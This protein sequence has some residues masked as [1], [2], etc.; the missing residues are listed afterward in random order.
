MVFTNANTKEQQQMRTAL[1]TK[2]T[3]TMSIDID[4]MNRPAFVPQ[5]LEYLRFRYE[6]EI[7]ELYTE[8]IEHEFLEVGDERRDTPPF[9]KYPGAQRAPFT[10]V[11]EYLA[12]LRWEQDEIDYA[13]VQDLENTA[14]K[15]RVMANPIARPLVLGI[16]WA[17]KQVVATRVVRDVALVRDLLISEMQEIAATAIHF[18][19]HAFVNAKTENEE[20]RAEV[21]VRHRI[22]TIYGRWLYKTRASAKLMATITVSNT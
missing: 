19:I 5:S 18:I 20:K 1:L 2:M 9:N 22:F 7:K 8:Y 15:R 12:A 4:K 17:L 14:L 6:K 11:T 21:T 3:Q 13:W 10:N 16:A